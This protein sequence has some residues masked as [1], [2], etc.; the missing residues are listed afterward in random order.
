MIY[1]IKGDSSK[2]ELLKSNSDFAKPSAGNSRVELAGDYYLGHFQEFLQRIERQYDAFLG[3]VELAFIFD[4]KALST[5][6]QRLWLRMLSRKGQVFPTAV[7]QYAEITD[8]QSAIAQLTAGGFVVPPDSPADLADWWQK[9]DKSQLWQLLQASNQLPDLIA[10]GLKRNADKATLQRFITEA[11]LLTLDNLRRS[12]S[13]LAQRRIEPLQYLLFLYF[14]RIET[15]LSAFTLRDLGVLP[16]GGFKTDYQARYTD[17]TTAQTA[18]FYASLRARLA[19]QL[20]RKNSA[21]TEV[22]LADWLQQ[23]PHWPAPLDEGTELARGKLCY[24][25]GRQAEKLR[26]PELAID[27]YRQSG[28]FP[29]SERLLRLYHQ[30]KM[31]VELELLLT[32]MQTDPSCDEEFYLAADFASRH[33]KER[34]QSDLTIQLQNA[35]TL[36]LDELHSQQPELGVCQYWQAQGYQ[37]VFA[38]NNLWLALFGLMLWQQLF[39]SSQSAILNEFERRPRD[40][41]TQDFYLNQQVAIEQQ[42]QILENPT[43]ACQFLLGQLSRHYGKANSIFSWQPELAQPLLALVRGAPAGALVQVLRKMAQDF[44]HHSSGYPDVLIWQEQQPGLVTDLQLIEVKAPGDSVRR[45]QLSRLFALRTLGFSAS[46]CR[47]NWYLD[48]ARVYAV[49]DVETT[50]GNSERDRITEIA[51]V[52]VQ[53]G[54]VI[55]RFSSLVNPGRRIP[56]FISKLTGIT[57]PM[58]AQAPDFAALAPQIWQQLQGCVFVAHNVRFD[59]GFVR[60]ELARCGY[61]LSMAQLC[62]VVE[63]RR[64]FSGL[65]S[66]SLASLCQHF[67][68]NLHEHHR[69]LA[70][71]QAAAQ[72]L[73]L[74]NQHRSGS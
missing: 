40:L 46:L 35:T 5:D 19:S 58:V 7:L 32:Q 74:I 44:R 61:Q 26:L 31:P 63:S 48:P 70:D 51:I 66:Y 28:A 16:T 29:A 62:T 60:A 9:A 68:I 20:P 12:A 10:G 39:E 6:A 57:D 8:Q 43:A 42:L 55:E 65:A 64:S 47:L 4:F 1:S 36:K 11:Q 73:Q 14:G 54:Q 69:A 27:W 2:G 45:N 38:E 13:L 67:S 22:Q 23:R 59:Y 50:G 17:S 49:I 56:G 24:A 71:A 41:T 18:Y 37:A 34:R 53:G 3:P 33:R 30:Q 52:K 72:L 21:L 15:N 25:L